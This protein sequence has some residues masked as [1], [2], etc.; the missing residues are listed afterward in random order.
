MQQTL[1]IK[2]EEY[3][4]GKWIDDEDHTGWVFTAEEVSRTKELIQY[5]SSLV[6]SEQNYQIMLKVTINELK[7]AILEFDENSALGLE[8][9][10]W[11]FP[12]TILL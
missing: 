3:K 5:I 12:H 11:S 4:V 8:G 10:F 6:T 1:D 2:Y 7:E 9:F